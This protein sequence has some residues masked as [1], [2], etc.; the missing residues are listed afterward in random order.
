MVIKLTEEQIK[1]IAT[2]QHVPLTEQWSR[3]SQFRLPK[4]SYDYLRQRW[5]N[6]AKRPRNASWRDEKKVKLATTTWIEEVDDLTMGIKFHETYIVQIDVTNTIEI[7]CAGWATSPMTRQRLD[8]C[9][10]NT[11]IKFSITNNVVYMFYKGQA[12][13]YEDGVK[14]LPTGDVR[15]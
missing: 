2:P 4:L 7:D 13:V 1:R 12:Y 10:W 5:E 6:E 15:L 8:D 3:G 14:I 9:L 11:G